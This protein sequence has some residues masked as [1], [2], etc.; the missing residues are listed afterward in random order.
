MCD[1]ILSSKKISTEALISLSEQLSED[2]LRFAEDESSNVPNKIK[3][4]ITQ[5]SES[6]DVDISAR[7]AAFHTAVTDPIINKYAMD[8]RRIGPDERIP[9]TNLQF[10]TRTDQ[11]INDDDSKKINILARL[12]GP[13]DEL[14]KAF[15]SEPE[16]H[17][18]YVRV[19]HDTLTR[20]LRLK[21]GDLDVFGPQLAYVEQL[22]FARYGLSMEELARISDASFKNAILKK[23]ELLLKRGAYMATTAGSVQKTSESAGQTQGK[24]ISGPTMQ[25]NIVNAIFGN[26]EFRRASE[27]KCTRT[28]TITIT[29]EAED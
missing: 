29:D 2:Y 25:E 27:K 6:P 7:K 3:Y 1:M 12:M 11:F 20:V 5:K 9:R 17:D 23:D 21:Q 15:G 10:W 8:T 28:I 24:V 14:K 22:M 19:L 16:W 4:E 18:S 13:L 26:T